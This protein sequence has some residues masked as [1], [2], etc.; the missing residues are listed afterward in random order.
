VR[1][2]E[3]SLFGVDVAPISVMVMAWVVTAALRRLASRFDLLRHVWHQALFAAAI[4]LIVLS[5]TVL[6]FARGG[7]HVR[8]RNRFAG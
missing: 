6:V 1:F 5:P 2:V 4:Y 7:F 8:Q 3:V